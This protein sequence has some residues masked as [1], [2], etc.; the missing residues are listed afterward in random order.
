MQRRIQYS[1][2]QFIHTHKKWNSVYTIQH[3]SKLLNSQHNSIIVTQISFQITLLQ[4]NKF[5][6]T[7]PFKMQHPDYQL[8]SPMLPLC[9]LNWKEHLSPV[10]GYKRDLKWL[11]QVLG[12]KMEQQERKRRGCVRVRGGLAV[13]GGHQGLIGGRWRQRRANISNGIFPLWWTM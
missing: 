1:F 4:Q 11:M 2:L 9:K 3:D 8:F 7:L 10:P 6:S 5:A 12:K 13:R